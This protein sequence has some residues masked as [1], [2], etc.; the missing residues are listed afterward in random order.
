MYPLP[1]S[2]VISQ[3]QN[4]PRW[5]CGP[6]LVWKVRLCRPLLPVGRY[7]GT[8]PGSKVC[9]L[10]RTRPA[11]AACAVSCQLSAQARRT[12][13]P[14]VPPWPAHSVTQTC[15]RT[16]GGGRIKICSQPCAM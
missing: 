13:S 1:I 4:L 8:S 5:L 14:A 2:P 10:R 7:P 16:H 9:S 15:Q 6:Y 3:T 11:A 12:E